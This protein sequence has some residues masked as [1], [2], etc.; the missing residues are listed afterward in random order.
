MAS[1][2]A[3]ADE[4]SD[5]S[6]DYRRDRARRGSVKDLRG[7]GNEELQSPFGIEEPDLEWRDGRALTVA[8]SGRM[9]GDEVAPEIIY[10]SDCIRTGKTPEHSGREGLPDVRIIRALYRSARTGGWRYSRKPAGRESPG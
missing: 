10:F 8:S 5:F 4:Q 9:D 2:L 3:M 7:S 1:L 6:R